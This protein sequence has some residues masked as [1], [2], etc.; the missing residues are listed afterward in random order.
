VAVE[1]D[2]D[3]EREPGGQTDMKQTELG[4][5][6]VEIKYQAAAEILLEVGPSFAVKDAEGGTGFHGREDGDQTL[7]N[8]LPLGELACKI[9]LAHL[10]LQKAKGSTGSVR[11]LL[12]VLFEAPCLLRPKRFEV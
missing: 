2:L 9:F 4:I 7:G 10:A 8:A 6:E 12:G 1:V 3:R 11:Q 5:E